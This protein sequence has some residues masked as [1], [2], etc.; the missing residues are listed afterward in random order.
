M[1]RKPLHPCSCPGCPNLTD[2]QFCPEHARSQQHLYNKYLRDP[3]TAKRYGRAWRRIRAR[4][5]TAHPLCEQC[6]KE[7]RLTPAQEIHHVLPL[8]EGGTHDEA[9]LMALCS[10]CHSKITGH[11][12][13]WGRR[14]L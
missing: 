4:F 10:S 9:N 2:K 6:L 3:E 1:P 5:I 7:G 13:P 12:N 8:S 14:N 11:D